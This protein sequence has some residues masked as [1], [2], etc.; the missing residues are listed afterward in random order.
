[1]G[2]YIV[3][4]LIG[5]GIVLNVVFAKCIIFE[6]FEIENLLNPLC[7]YEE[8]EVNVFGCAV[9]TILG[10]LLLAPIAVCYWFYKLCTVGRK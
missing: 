6:D 8:V 2:W 4:F 7:I 3:G 1:M 10:N 9:L 5:L